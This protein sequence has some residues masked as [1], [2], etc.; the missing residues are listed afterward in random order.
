MYVLKDF[1]TYPGEANFFMHM[2][3]KEDYVEQVLELFHSSIRMGSYTD[4]IIA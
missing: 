3:A 1:A 2:Y 4:L